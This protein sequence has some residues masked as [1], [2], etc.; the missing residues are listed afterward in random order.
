MAIRPNRLR[1][2]RQI[3]SGAA[4]NF[5]NA[6]PG[7]QIKPRHGARSD[8]PRQ[9]EKPLEE[10]IDRSQAII[11]PAHELGFVFDPSAHGIYECNKGPAQL[12]YRRLL[13][14]QLQKLR[15]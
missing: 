14:R 10:D 6:I 8:A 13:L 15:C 11:S 3:A 2:K 12:R 5:E 1:E 4:A 7:F 9:P